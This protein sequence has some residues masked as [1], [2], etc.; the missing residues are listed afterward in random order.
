MLL[1]SPRRLVFCKRNSL[2]GN[3]WNSIS[4]QIECSYVD[5]VESGIQRR[6]CIQMEKV[7]GVQCGGFREIHSVLHKLNRKEHGV[8]RLQIEEQVETNNAGNVYKNL[9]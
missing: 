3:E 5:A 8:M 1:A 2:S 4:A 6:T 9:L 7:K